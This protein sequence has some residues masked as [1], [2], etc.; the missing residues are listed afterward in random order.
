MTMK[1]KI[2]DILEKMLRTCGE[3]RSH[4][5]D[6]FLEYKLDYDMPKLVEALKEC[7]EGK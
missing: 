5:T 7:K 1:E 6:H 3:H 4:E 2:E